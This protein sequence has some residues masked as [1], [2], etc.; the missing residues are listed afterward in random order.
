MTGE[1]PDGLPRALRWLLSPP[2]D[3]ALA[4]HDPAAGVG[5][6]AWPA[7][8]YPELG[9]RAAKYAAAIRN[10]GLAEGKLVALAYP[11]SPELIS[12]LCAAMGSGVTTCVLPTPHPGQSASSYLSQ[13]AGLF[14]LRQPDAVLCHDDYA[15]ALARV[16]TTRTPVLAESDVA[17]EA[18][19]S[20]SGRLVWFAGRYPLAQFTSG[21]T[22]PQRGVLVSASALDANH[23]ALA[24]HLALTEQDVFVSWLPHNHD[25]GLVGMLL[26]TLHD[27]RSGFFMQPQHFIR[28]PE[29]YLRCLADSH[30]T[31]TAL[32]NFALE[33]ILRRVPDR[34][35]AGL[36]L[37]GLRAVILGGERVQP[38]LL[39]RFEAR[40][41][42]Y[43]LSATALSPA[44]GSAEATLAISLSPPGVPWR[45]RPA[46]ADPAGEPVVSCGPPMAGLTIRI[47]DE[48]GC[49]QPPGTLGEIAVSGPSTQTVP[50]GP[51]HGPAP[52]TAA[53]S[54]Q[55]LRTG[56]AGFLAGGEL[57][58]VGRFG[59]AVKVRAVMV[60]AESLEAALVA[61]GLAAGDTTVLLGNPDVVT[62]VFL[63]SGRHPEQDRIA[64]EVTREW[65]GPTA[66]AFA[67][68]VSGG[69]IRR[70]SSG[71]PRRRALWLDVTTGLL[72][73]RRRRL[74]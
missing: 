10:R 68:D 55:E 1:R 5:P 50:L 35:L 33:H 70:T 41:R 28:Y 3:R 62:A 8:G 16:L 51:A 61:R 25:M 71:K 29:R 52:F 11:T 54:S 9:R 19:Q 18:R 39:E 49:P 63:F 43:G 59:D 46:P 27:A 4:C 72:A 64:G 24:Q 44:Y 38:R 26:G 66:T 53:L 23:H 31:V 67:I 56:D 40:L 48:T 65:L 36:D 69:E 34:A 57:F 6:S 42:G 30:A 37:S 45:A 15:P 58:V 14:G 47:L 12:A 73:G 17:Q 74:S 7:V 2:A 22:G 21:S 13:L 60:F 20:G 32:P